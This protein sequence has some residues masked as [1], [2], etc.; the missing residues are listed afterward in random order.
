MARSPSY[1]P[2]LRSM[3]STRK[4]RSNKGVTRAGVHAGNLDRLFASPAVKATRAKPVVTTLEGVHNVKGRQVYESIR[5]KQYVLG[6][7]KKTGKQYKIYKFTREG[8]AVGTRAPVVHQVVG[9]NTKGR[10]IMVSSKG[11]KGASPKKFVMAV[12]KTGKQYRVY[13]FHTGSTPED[14]GMTRLFKTRKTRKNAG[15]KRGPR[16]FPRNTSL[17]A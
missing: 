11:R 14:M 5:H 15:V 1:G 9:V 4:P 7:S 13:K 17:F 6:T 8:V 2:A 3:F 16:Y 10:Q 12:S